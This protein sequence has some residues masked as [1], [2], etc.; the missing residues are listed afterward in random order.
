MTAI[1]DINGIVAHIA[2]WIVVICS[3]PAAI[4]YGLM[5]NDAIK[6]PPRIPPRGD[7]GDPI[8]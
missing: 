8:G 2:I 7:H 5:M 4:G 6:A 1:A 3:V